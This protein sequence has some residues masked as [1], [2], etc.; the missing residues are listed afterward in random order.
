MHKTASIL[1]K[2]EAKAYRRLM[3]ETSGLGGS[4]T[5]DATGRL[6]AVSGY[7]S[8]TSS[9]SGSESEEESRTPAR[10]GSKRRTGS[11]GAQASATGGAPKGWD[12]RPVFG[13]RL[14]VDGEVV[15]ATALGTASERAM[16]REVN[17]MQQMPHGDRE[18]LRTMVA[19]N[20]KA[21]LDKGGRRTASRIR[22]TSLKEDGTDSPPRSPEMVAAS[23]PSNVRASPVQA[24]TYGSPVA[25]G[26]AKLSGS[27]AKRPL[28]SAARA[29]RPGT[30]RVTTAPVD[31][32]PASRTAPHFTRVMA[33]EDGELQRLV[34]VASTAKREAK[35]MEILL[36]RDDAYELPVG[37][38]LQ[39]LL[40][41]V[42][43]DGITAKL[44]VPH[45]STAAADALPRADLAV[46]AGSE[47]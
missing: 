9:S 41:Y 24:R 6:S 27:D 5:K 35:V 22:R 30:S 28:H 7:E 19:N 36:K 17:R 11:R 32:L 16:H 37:K 25:A 39:S 18:R 45:G 47:S 3:H 8:V 23:A 10:P 43:P 26:L 20:A 44:V 1:E 4:A 2:L 31:G 33:Q 13:E 40:A 46:E 14:V 21:R 29:S 12:G 15:A 42:Q 38:D 34:Q